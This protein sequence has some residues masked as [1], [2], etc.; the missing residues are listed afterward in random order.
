MNLKPVCVAIL[1]LWLAIPPALATP[2]PWAPAHGWRAKNDP[3]YV[4][5]AGRQWSDDY[6]VIEGRCNTDK[7]L[8]VAGAV[9][10]GAI[11][12]RVASPE[13]R[14]I[15][16]VI[17]AIVGGV[18]GDAIGRRIDENDRACVGQALELARVGQR[19][20][21]TNPKTGQSYTVR[22]REDLADGCRRFELASGDRSA[23]GPV[24]LTG[25]ASK[26]GEW[27]LR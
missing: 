16:T 8:A 14:A 2:P 1:G 5:Y 27:R 10:G 23:G 21:W 20:R 15:A 4:G 22:P 26:D 12:N 13:G 9:A 3:F 6:G 18:V 24:L 19:V 11:G 7:V 25:C 17:G